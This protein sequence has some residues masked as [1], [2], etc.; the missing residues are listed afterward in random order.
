MKSGVQTI[1][2]QNAVAQIGIDRRADRHIG[3]R[4][5]LDC[6]LQTSMAAENAAGALLTHENAGTGAVLALVIERVATQVRHGFGK[7]PNV[8]EKSEC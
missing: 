7:G 3:L 4:S 8:F 1:Q 2:S 6:D 5:L